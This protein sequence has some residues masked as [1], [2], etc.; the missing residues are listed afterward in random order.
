MLGQ[1]NYDLVGAGT[2]TPKPDGTQDLHL[3]LTGLSTTSVVQ[4]VEVID[5]SDNEQWFYQ[6]SGSEPQIVFDRGSGATTADIFIQP[7]SAHLD[8][9]FT[10]YLE[11]ANE[12]G[13]IDIPVQGVVFN[14]N[15]SVL[16]AVPQAPLALGASSVTT[17][18]VPLSWLVA[19]GATSY[20]VER[21]LATTPLS[22]T[23][24]APDVT[25]T[26]YTDTTVSNATAYE[27]AV[28]AA[29][30]GAY[31]AFG[32]PLTVTTGSPVDVLAA[33]ALTP[34]PIRGQTFTATI[35]LFSDTD[36]STSA[37][38]FT[39][40]IN[41]GDWMTS[42]GTIY[43][44]DGS[45]SVVGTHTYSSFGNFPVSVKITLGSPVTAS[46]STVSTATVSP[47][48]GAVT[49]SSYY[50]EVG[51][52]TTG[53]STKGALGTGANESYS[54]TALGG[55]TITWNSAPFT[56]GSANANDAVEATGQTIAL[57]CTNCSSIELLAAATNGANQGGVITIDYSGGSSDT[58][59][60]GLSDWTGGYGGAGSNAPGET[61]V[62]NMSGFE[63][64]SGTT[65]AATIGSAF[66]YGYIIPTNSSKTITGLVLPN[67][68]A[69][70][71]LAID[72]IEQPSQLNLS[73]YFDAVG[74]TTTGSNVSGQLA[75]PTGSSY[76]SAALGGSTIT[77]NSQTFD[78]GP[79]NAADVILV[80]GTS[81]ALPPGSY[82]SIEVLAASM[83]GSNEAIPANIY[84]SDGSTSYNTVGFSDWQQG[85]NGANTNA[86]G[87]TTVVSM[88]AYESFSGGA[89]TSTTGNAF[90][91][92]YT[93][94][95]N[96]NKTAT[97]LALGN[98]NAI[99]VLAIDLVSQPPQVNLGYGNSS[100]VTLPYNEIGISAASDYSQGAIDSAGDSYSAAAAPAG[101]GN[102]VTW[103]GQVFDFGPAGTNDVVEANGQSV[104]LPAGSYNALDILGAS[105]S[106]Y[107]ETAVFYV[108]YVGGSYDTFTQAFSDW[109][110]GYLG[111]TPETTAPGESIVESPSTYNKLASGSSTG[112]VYLYGYVF[113]LSAGKTVAY[114]KLPTDTSIKILAMDEVSSPEQVNLAA[115]STA[116]AIPVADNQIGISTTLTKALGNLDGKGDT[117]SSAAQPNGLGNSVTWNSQTF[118][119]GPA[120]YDDFVQAD[121]QSI[122]LPQGQYTSL[123][124]LGASTSGFPETNLFTVHYTNATFDTIT[125]AFSDWQNGYTGTLGTTAPG[126][127]IAVAMNTYLSPT[128]VVNT[129]VDLY[130]YVFPVNP[131]ETVSYL[132]LPDDPSVVILAIDEVYQPE[133]VNLGDATNSAAPAFNTIGI[134]TNARTA[135]TGGA[136]TYSANALG[137]TVVWNGQTFDI[138][139]ATVSVND[140]VATAGNPAITLP[141][142]QYTSVEFLASAVG[143]QPASGNYSIN[144]TN[145]TSDT[146][147][148]GVSSWSQGYVGA[149]TTAA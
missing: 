124:I 87:E 63:T 32:Q 135:V 107:E 81:I 41:W 141:Q 22:W 3:E 14:P 125:Q 44:E 102:S 89:D 129:H 93:I 19:P 146:F 50:N 27:Y 106:G 37:S 34:S 67:D 18:Q 68:S 76:S 64:Y 140:A 25:G 149:N 91:C 101:L 30:S 132:L 128:A 120:A 45:F 38:S 33:Q 7:T 66:L 65:N 17:S 15:L 122:E 108:H 58:D 142:G 111:T 12:S 53:S 16:P 133:Q 112:P 147:T 117:Y 98:N 104:T 80:G 138:G 69:I 55:S 143:G 110:A 114:I 116:A 59:A 13:A 126:E 85:Y 2:G 35:A 71:V 144:Y 46:A 20:I 29:E 113:P 109:K 4:S 61:T 21:S 90:A 60:L 5:N 115:G 8:D 77:W 1:D 70:A 86:P 148:L 123:M 99:M 10:I 118:A 9:T 62:V 56:L 79:A 96:P 6:E 105:T 121:G 31:S 51:I 78:L 49:L 39:A 139:P 127:S 40:T 54:S 11:Y 136:S 95:V 23:V 47:P 48:S 72:E 52:T 83:R 97:W 131:T 103:N 24:I 42:P 74:I 73:G 145:G 100:G 130:G 84:Y 88:S 28:A 57:N 137:N 75:S 92:G 82:S 36:E 119:I 43:G 26:S 134:S 94:P